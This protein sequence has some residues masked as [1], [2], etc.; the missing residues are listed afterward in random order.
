MRFEFK[1][2]DIIKIPGKNFEDLSLEEVGLMIDTD[3]SFSENG[4][5]YFASCALDVFLHNT[6]LSRKDLREIQQNILA[7]IYLDI[8][9]SNIKAINKE[10]LRNLSAKLKIKE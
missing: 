4:N 2:G 5:A 1:S 3:S 9:G 6:D 10:Y 8:P 7:N